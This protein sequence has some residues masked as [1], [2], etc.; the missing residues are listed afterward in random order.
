MNECPQNVKFSRVGTVALLFTVM[1]LLFRLAPGT[2]SALKKYLLNESDHV[3][4]FDL[5]EGL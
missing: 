2:E 3:F 5:G 4:C 1:T